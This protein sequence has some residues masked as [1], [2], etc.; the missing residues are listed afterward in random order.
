VC[1][2]V[3]VNFGALKKASYVTPNLFLALPALLVIDEPL[4]CPYELLLVLVELLVLI[5][6]L[7]EPL[8]GPYE[9]LLSPYEPLLVIDEP[10][11]MIDEPLLAIDEPLLGL[12]EL[13]VELLVLIKSIKSINQITLLP[14]HYTSLGSRNLC[15]SSDHSQDE[16]VLKSNPPT[17]HKIHP[18]LVMGGHG[19]LVVG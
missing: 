11:L 18:L 13:L 4:L 3:V 7:V 17:H 6:V 9:P 14:I 10:L 2:W 12:V 8:L 19:K 5:L 16:Y 1:E 15:G